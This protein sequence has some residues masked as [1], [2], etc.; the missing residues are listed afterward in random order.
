MPGGTNVIASRVDAW[1]DLRGDV[2]ASTRA[3]LA[4][5]L[6]AAEEAAAAQRL[7]A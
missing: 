3:L 6:A 2:D 5:V 4:E 1:L 7:R